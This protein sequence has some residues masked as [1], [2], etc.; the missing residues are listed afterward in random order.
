MQSFIEPET[1]KLYSLVHF[2]LRD[3]AYFL[4]YT[5]YYGVSDPCL[6]HSNNPIVLLGLSSDVDSISSPLQPSSG[7]T[8]HLQDGPPN[9][10]HTTPSLTPIEN[11]GIIPFLGVMTLW[12]V[13]KVVFMCGK[14]LGTLWWAL[15][16]L[17]GGGGSTGLTGGVMDTFGGLCVL[18]VVWGAGQ[19]TQ[20]CSWWMCQRMKTAGKSCLE[21]RPAG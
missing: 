11:S 12:Y 13:I 4:V 1:S 6:L 8:A 16:G 19:T 5:V 9:W 2:S 7:H 10:P 14:G 17:I 18:V 20:Q 3:Q 21:R 15:P